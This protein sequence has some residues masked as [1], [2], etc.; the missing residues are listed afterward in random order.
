MHLC[1]FLA[2]QRGVERIVLMAEQSFSMACQLEAI[3]TEFIGG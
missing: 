3:S 1:S 2:V